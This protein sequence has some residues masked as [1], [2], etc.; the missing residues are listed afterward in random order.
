MIPNR[1][2]R[3]IMDK[4]TVALENCYGIRKLRHQFDFSQ[5]KAYAIYAP[6]GSMKSSFA[7]TFKNIADGT[8]PVD[9]IFPERTS[10]S[11]I[12]DENSF[13]AEKIP[14]ATRPEVGENQTQEL[15]KKFRAK[16]RGE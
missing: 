16:H 6:N 9:R 8:K 3:F 15:L 10:V 11:K 4:I 7:A 13:M 14:D 1:P 12:T 5:R 2:T